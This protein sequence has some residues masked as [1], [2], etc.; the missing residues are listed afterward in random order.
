MK[1]QLLQKSRC[2][3]TTGKKHF[4]VIPLVL[5]FILVFMPTMYAANFYSGGTGNWNAIQWYSDGSRTIPVGGIPG[6]TD[7]VFIGSGHTVTLNGNRTVNTI[8]VNDDGSGGQ[9]TGNSTLTISAGLGSSIS[10]ATA[11]CTPQNLT[12]QNGADLTLSNGASLTVGSGTS[13]TFTI[14]NGTFTMNNAS[15]QMT[16]RYRWVMTNATVTVNNGSISVGPTLTSSTYLVDINS[17]TNVTFNNGTMD[18]Y[19]AATSGNSR[20]I[21]FDGNNSD[22]NVNGGTITIGNATTGQ[23]NIRWRNAAGE[24]SDV[25]I[26]GASAVLT[27][28]DR[29][30]SNATNSDNDL[31]ITNSGTLNLETG[32]NDASG[33]QS[34]FSGNLTLSNGGV[35]NAYTNYLGYMEVYGNFSMDGASVFN[36]GS[37]SCNS[38]FPAIPGANNLLPRLVLRG[39]GTT[40][41]TTKL[42]IYGGI[43]IRDSHT[44]T[45]D[46]DTLE[47]GNGVPYNYEA[48]V[49]DMQGGSCI[50]NG[51]TV[52][53]LGRTITEINNG[54]AD[55]IFD[56]NGSATF[57]MNG[58]SK[59]IS[60]E[61]VAFL[62]PGVVTGMHGNATLEMYSNSEFWSAQTIGRVQGGN[63]TRLDNN[64]IIHMYGNSEFNIAS[65]AQTFAGGNAL[66]IG[67]SGGST[68]QIILEG[69]SRFRMAESIDSVLSG[70]TLVVNNNSSI[71]ISGTAEMH[72]G[73]SLNVISGGNL[74]NIAG[75]SSITVNTGGKLLVAQSPDIEVPNTT[76][77]LNMAGSAQLIIDGGQVGVAQNTPFQLGIPVTINTLDL[78]GSAAVY[79]RNGGT[80]DIG[81]GNRGNFR[82]NGNG[83]RFEL[84]NGTVNVTASMDMSSNN[85]N[86]TVLVTGGTLN[87]G[88]EQSQGTNTLTFNDNNAAIDSFAVTGGTVSIGDGNSLIQMGNGNNNPTI[89]SGDYNGIFL[90]GTGTLNVYGRLLL[91][92][93]SNRIVMTGG[94][95]NIDPQGG[96]D[97]LTSGE[98][99]F[100]LNRG[101]VEFSGGTLTFINPSLAEGSG[102]IF[103]VSPQGNPGSGDFLSGL[104]SLPATSAVT[105]TGNTIN[106]GNGV[107]TATGSDEGF[108][109]LLDDSHTYG[110]IVVNNPSGTNRFVDLVNNNDDIYMIGDLTITSGQFN[111]NNNDI[112]LLSGAGDFVLGSNA[113][114][115]MTHTDGVNH[116]PGYQLGTYD[117]YTL[118]LSST[119]VYA[120]ESSSNTQVQQPG[121][122]FGNVTVAGSGTKRFQ[123]TPTVRGTLRLEGGTANNNVIMAN[124]STLQRAGTDASGIMTGSVQGGNDYTIEYV[125]TD[126]TTQSNEFSGTGNKSLIVNLDAS[127]TLDLHTNLT[128]QH[129]LT[130]SSGTFDD[131]GNILTVNRNITNNATH[132]STTGRIELTGGSLQHEISGNDNG[133]FGHLELDDANGAILNAKQT[134]SS[135]LTLTTGVLELN[136]NELV[137]GQTASISVSSPS[138]SK[139]I[140]MAGTADEIGLTKQFAGTFSFEYPI[141]VSGK[142]TPAQ[143]QILTTSS[144]GTVTIKPINQGHPFVTNGGTTNLSYYWTAAN[145]GFSNLS[146]T[147]D[148]TYLDGDVQGI[149]TSYIPAA[150]SPPPVEWT[151]IEDVTEV[152]EVG[153]V[154][155]FNAISF[156]DG[157]FTAGESSEFGSIQGFYSLLNNAAWDSVGAWS[158]DGFTGAPTNDLPGSSNPVFIGN[159]KTII[160]T[161]MATPPTLEIQSTGTLVIDNDDSASVDLGVVSGEGT[162]RLVSND[163]DTPVFPSGTFTNFLGA[164]GGTLGYSGTGN[165]TLLSAPASVRNLTISGTGT[166]ITPNLA[167]IEVL[168]N[169]RIESGATVQLDSLAD[170]ISVG[171]NLTITGSGSQLQLMNNTGVQTLNIWGNVTVASGATMDVSTSAAAREHQI[172]IGG[173]LSNSGTFDMNPDNIEDAYMANVTF[174]GSSDETISGA[175]ATTDFERLIIDKGSSQTPVLQITAD[176]FELSGSTDGATKALELTNGT[177][178]LSSGDTITLSSKPPTGAATNFIIPATSRLWIDNASAVA[179]IIGEAA[180]FLD[181]SGTLQ[182][183]DGKVIVG[184]DTRGV[185]DNDIQYKGLAAAITVA[186]GSLDVSGSIIPNGTAALVYEQTGGTV[187]LGLYKANSNG[188]N[189]IT[190]AD[191]LLNNAASSFTMSGSSQMIFNRANTT[192]DGM[193]FASQNVATYSVTGGTVQIINSNTT[194]NGFDV[195]ISTTIPFWNLQI[196]DGTNFSGRVGGRNTAGVDVTVLNDFTINIPTG[197]FKTAYAGNGNRNSNPFDLTIGGDFTVTAGTFLPSLNNGN[198]GTI[199]FNGSGAQL[200]SDASGELNVNYMTVDKSSGSVQLVSGTDLLVEGNFTLSNGSFDPNGELVKFSA[201]QNENQSINGNV[202]FYD[203][204][205]DKS[206]TNNTLTL[207]SGSLTVTNQLT[208][209]NG[210]LDIGDNALS[211]TSTSIDTVLGGAFGANRMIVLSGTQS[212]AGITKSY[213][214]SAHDFTF[215]FGSSG[216]YRP[217]R[218]NVTNT[219]GSAGTITMKPVA[220]RHPLATGSNNAITYYWKASNTGFGGGLQVTHQYFYEQSDVPGANDGAYQGGYYIPTTWTTNAAYTIAGSGGSSGTRTLQFANLTFVQGDFTSGDPATAFDALTTYYSYQTGNWNDGNSW[221]TTGVG[222]LPIAGSIPTSS[223]PVV[224]GSNHTITMTTNNQVAASVNIQNSTATLDLVSTS[225]HNL[226]TGISGVGT[227]KTN[228]NSNLPTL[229]ASFTQS[230]GG[231]VE[232]AGG[233][234]TLPAQSTYNNLIVSSGNKTLNTNKTINGNVSVTGGQLRID[235]Y[236]L[237]RSSVGGS[238]TLA[239]GTTLRVRGSNNFPQNYG[240]YTLDAAST[241]LYD[242][243]INQTI[244]GITYGN[245]TLRR[246]NNGAQVSKTLDGNVTINGNL[247]IGTSGQPSRLVQFVSSNYSVTINGDLTTYTGGSID[248]GQSEFSFE[249]GSNQ[250]VAGNVAPTFYD[251]TVN[252]GSAVTLSAVDAEVS[253][254]LAMTNGSLDIN[255][256]TLT[257][258]G[259]AS[260]T[261]TLIG[262]ATSNLSISGTGALGTLSFAGGGQTLNNLSIDRTSTGTATLGSDLSVNGT[263]TL[264]NGVIDMGS[265]ELTLTSTAASPI[266]GGNDS[267]FVEGSLAM[268]FGSNLSRT[269]EVGAGTDYRPVTIEGSPSSNPSLSVELIPSA[270]T[271]GSKESTI[272]L[273]SN[274]RYYRIDL[275]SGTLSSQFVEITY[276]SDATVSNPDS[277]LVIRSSNNNDWTDEG[278]STN[279][280]TVP[281]G[282]VKSSILLPPDDIASET[283]FALGS[284]GED[285]PLPVELASYTLNFVSNG[286]ELAWVT[287]TETDNLGFIISRSESENGQYQQIASYNSSDLLKGQG[288]TSQ[289]TEYAYTDFSINQIPGKTYFYR[290]EDV[291]IT[292]KRNKLEVKQITLPE[293]YALAQNYP[294]PFNPTTT[295]QF[296]LKVPGKTSLEVY[297]ILGRK[298]ATLLNQEMKA[299]AHVVNWN[300]RNYASGVYFYR[301]QSGNFAQVKK[302][303]LVK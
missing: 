111:L 73:D 103:Q 58:S 80:L 125:G 128:I 180:Q 17:N 174:I 173:S 183:S 102:N 160:I 78:D 40:N 189:Q 83:S 140:L 285:N 33:T 13:G 245:L 295:I 227:L 302:M 112:G 237:N 67:A 134:I 133:V 239:S 137:I 210:L 95:L 296:N 236:T 272:D 105:F 42:S 156:V 74:F 60:G 247:T 230:G 193:S 55:G 110:S 8:T 147:L 261:G 200:L 109:V 14:N 11:I 265:N 143:V 170:S 269:Y 136:K 281:R 9:L 178:R 176:N 43:Q 268:Y 290:L 18:I 65:N 3:N 90:S 101:L 89:A 186:G 161:G 198:N 162:L 222:T 94:N 212:A 131:N 123:S 213:P 294:N 118:D 54:D 69:N 168:N 297:D 76:Q 291:D 142:Y 39:S 66:N 159:S 207:S 57:T 106:F 202:S 303:M 41:I 196:G 68:C 129:D 277:L 270:P 251:L 188:A 225:G 166:K 115:Y 271:V 224:I 120:G 214:S 276:D 273:I 217:A 181:L 182:L 201:S 169:L 91:D 4:K 23:G 63:P 6:S 204:E 260:G 114:L 130:L 191:F 116:F 53:R 187:N 93:A 29:F 249:S 199:T 132:V 36:L 50:L 184:N 12:I 179:Q 92:D 238:F 124:G 10:G 235:A 278:Q 56:L 37:T 104:G 280:G 164:T 148:F 99:V 84:E 77:I 70:N 59:V 209:T 206:T 288:T 96:A 218:M 171:G 149:E 151:K 197:T 279:S 192:A 16:L 27:L 98:T 299:G 87:I 205:V 262:S 121:T 263:L 244:K 232:Y 155:T 231:T 138:A 208:L 48:E 167:S 122:P 108:D 64:A 287:A 246:D 126:K 165:Y 203:L 223:N 242:Y 275:I 243:R 258:S 45:V 2:N 81:G 289:Q 141:G 226:G 157:D 215:P 221:S 113:T 153:N 264:T 51:S 107:A 117:S 256:Q 293:D 175:G 79:V 283:Y 158:Y 300:A 85:S 228:S 1:K 22:F 30:Y 282:T 52:M 253:N 172:Q 44:L 274:T 241:V 190:T 7:D 177:L 220:S 19:A 292:G 254:Q 146:A 257:L 259:T 119:V 31:T 28:N 100:D 46:T 49:F 185:S 229:D 21:V 145:T 20:G 301:L 252:N 62:Q 255:G 286:V 38:D 15:T 195:G 163:T 61:A 86:S 250:T 135:T 152:D 216:S 26:S 82:L 234:F 97:A 72:V 35:L 267:S 144:P 248:A 233:N 25:T 88:V 127:N 5:A 47:L 34:R 240:T 266:S 75:S 211:L 150:Y 219:G 139:M 32:S 154:I 71:S 194:D 298:V 24:R 284:I